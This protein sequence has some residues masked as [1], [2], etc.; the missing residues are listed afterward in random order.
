MIA[1]L[2]LV[3]EDLVTDTEWLANRLSG[4]SLLPPRAEHDVREDQAK[5]IELVRAKTPMK[6]IIKD[7][8]IQKIDAV[9]GCIQASRGRRTKLQTFVSALELSGAKLFRQ[10]EHH[11]EKLMVDW[12]KLSSL[13]TQ[14]GGHKVFGSWCDWG[15]P[16]DLRYLQQHWEDKAWRDLNMD[17][18]GHLHTN[19]Q[20][21]P[22]C[23]TLTETVNLEDLTKYAA[24]GTVVACPCS[25]ATCA[26]MPLKENS[27]FPCHPCGLN[28]TRLQRMVGSLLEGLPAKS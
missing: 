17:E 11:F 4:A 14:H 1:N 18:P 20:F 25:K 10:M 5:L 16:F 26:A 12:S 28:T 7:Y 2:G 21:R 9:P 27:M 3:H 19:F 22:T 15:C 23:A 24:L 6:R 8:L 13:M